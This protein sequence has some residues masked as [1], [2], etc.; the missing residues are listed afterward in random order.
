M[1]SSWSQCCICYSNLI[2][3][4]RQYT[5][6]SIRQVFIKMHISHWLF[7][8]WDDKFF[9][10]QCNRR[11]A[12][13]GS[14]GMCL[15]DS[16]SSS[17]KLSRCSPSDSVGRFWKSEIPVTWKALLAVVELGLWSKLAIAPVVNKFFLRFSFLIDPSFKRKKSFLQKSCTPC[18][19]I[20]RGKE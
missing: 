20:C 2:F 1:Q 11:Q 5:F 19:E 14:G 7:K 18:S 10:L 12:C 13:V 9:F 15:W 16:T 6:S 8:S 3:A 17:F 4:T